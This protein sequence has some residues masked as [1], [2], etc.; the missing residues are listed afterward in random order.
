MREEPHL[1][2]ETDFGNFMFILK[3]VSCIRLT[4]QDHKKGW[5]SFVIYKSGMVSTKVTKGQKILFKRT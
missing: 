2:M 4:D 1:L 5:I 3:R